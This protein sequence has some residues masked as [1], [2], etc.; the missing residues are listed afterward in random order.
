MP[1][2]NGVEFNAERPSSG[3]HSKKSQQNTP[4][5]TDINPITRLGINGFGMTLNVVESHLDRYDSLVAEFMKQQELILVL[6]D[7]WEYHVEA[8]GVQFPDMVIELG[9]EYRF[10]VP[11]ISETPYQF[12]VDEVNVSKSITANNETWSAGD[13]G[14]SLATTG[15]VPAI[16]DVQVTGGALGGVYDRETNPLSQTDAGP[17]SQINTTY[18]LKKTFTFAADSNFAWKIRVVG[19]DVRAT[20][21]A[22]TGYG[23]VTIQATSLYSGLETT[24]LEESKFGT[25]YTPFSDTV[26]EIGANNETVTI[27]F[28]VHGDVSFSGQIINLD[29]ESSELRLA[30]CTGVTIHNTADTTTVMDIS[31]RIL[32]EMVVVINTDGTGS[33]AYSEDFDDAV[34]ANAAYALSGVTQDVPNDEIDIADDGYLIYQIDTKYPIV[35]VPTLT[36]QIDITAG[37]PTLQISIDGVTFYDIDTVIVDDILTEYELDNISNIRLDGETSIYFRFDCGGAG[38]NT[39]RIKTFA[40]GCNTITVDAQ[41]PIIDIGSPNTFKCVQDDDSSFTCIIDLMYN[42]RKYAA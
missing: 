34:Y 25:V 9:E 3:A 29:V 17:Y 5:G 35:G 20:D 21:G 36:S 33:V 4:P 42:H 39:C 1:T 23:K 27:R 12:S 41:H 7:G 18:I 40:F 14:T 15:T 31:N 32:P 19:F 2:I 22:H 24:I 30:G 16:P 26:D 38:T 6:R 28:Y 37:I 11:L 10:S 8:V 13:D